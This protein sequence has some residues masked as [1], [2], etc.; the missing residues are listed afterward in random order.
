MNKK[1]VGFSFLFIAPFTCSAID[2]TVSQDGAGHYETIQ[3]AITAISN[4]PD[5]TP[6][7]DTTGQTACFFGKGTS[8][9]NNV[10]G[11]NTTWMSDVSPGDLIA[12]EGSELYYEVSEV[13]TDSGLKITRPDESDNPFCG[14]YRVVEMNTIEIRPGNY[15]ETLDMTDVHFLHLKGSSLRESVV[16]TSTDDD[17]FSMGDIDTMEYYP[18]YFVHTYENIT[19]R[20]LEFGGVIEF[21]EVTGVGGRDTSLTIINSVLSSI[22]CDLLYGYGKLGHLTILDSVISG[23]GDLIVSGLESHDP[24]KSTFIKNTTIYSANEPGGVQEM[25]GGIALQLTVEGNSV[26]EDSRITCNASIGGGKCAKI[27]GTNQQPFTI[28]NTA[29]AAIGGSEY[30]G[31][32]IRDASVVLDNVQIETNDVGGVDIYIYGNSTVTANCTD[33]DPTAI[34]NQ[35]VFTDLGCSP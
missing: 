27:I 26:I 4:L 32:S 12:L 5:T 2:L 18:E 7:F 19:I 17:V 3:E 30:Q 9:T 6:K 15:L 22:C 29:I 23:G 28:K 21:N 13:L 8:L 31:L 34:I 16:I 35:G 24:V 14:P 20:N 25:M 33:Y 1:L 10:F 11:T